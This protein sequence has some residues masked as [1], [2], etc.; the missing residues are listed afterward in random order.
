MGHYNHSFLC[1]MICAQYWRSNND[2]LLS[3]SLAFK[4]NL[5]INMITKGTTIHKVQKTRM[6][7]LQ[8]MHMQTYNICLHV[9]TAVNKE[10]MF[11]FIL[12]R[13]KCLLHCT[14]IDL[15]WI[16]FCSIKVVCMIVYFCK[17]KSKYIICCSVLNT[18]SDITY[19]YTQD[20]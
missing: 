10:N 14:F 18:W 20:N 5:H 15:S 11:R 4:S 3:V 1:H 8:V 13:K 12:V 19:F 9:L 2:S 16:L 6:Q 17:S 7:F